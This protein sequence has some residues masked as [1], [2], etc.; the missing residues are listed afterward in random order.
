MHGLW[1]VDED[2]AAVLHQVLF[3]F[4]EVALTGSIYL[5]YG[6]QW[7]VGVDRTEVDES[8]V[9]ERLVIACLGVAVFIEVCTEVLIL[10]VI[11]TVGT[12]EDFL[13][14]SLYIFHI[15]CG[16]EHV[17]I[18]YLATNGIVAQTAVEVGCT[19]NF[20]AQV[21]TTIHEVAN[22]WEAVGTDIRFCMSEDVG[23]TRTGKA[24]EDTSVT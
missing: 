5:F 22:V 1:Y 8:I 9:Q 7:V 17:G 4:T 6:V 2:I 20:T 13:H 24:V 15:G 16:V 14:A 11:H 23:I 3:L 19:Q 18:R 21:V 12:T 10:I